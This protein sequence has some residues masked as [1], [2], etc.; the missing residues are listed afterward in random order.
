MGLR[1]L[2]P[3]LSSTVRRLMFS[4]SGGSGGS[5]NPSA[6]PS[7]LLTGLQA[8]YAFE[9]LTFDSTG[10]GNTLT[11]NN[12]VTQASGILGQAASFASASS[13]SLSHA[14]SAPFVMSGNT[15][16]TITG[17]INLATFTGLPPL[18]GKDDGGTTSEYVVCVIQ[19]THEFNFTVSSNG[20]SFVSVSLFSP[21]PTTGTWYFLCA[22]YD[23]VNISLSV[24]N[25]TPVTTAFSA[26]VF[27][28]TSVFNI[29]RFVRT[30]D[31]T[32]GLIDQVGI[33]KVALTPTQITAL[34]GSGSPPAYPFTGIP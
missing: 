2:E 6:A 27:A 33:W 29:G 5:K 18:V 34:Y 23:G 32:N 14:S 1:R 17:W 28:G 31:F 21:V 20:T 10:N 13:Q 11:N 16:F 22:K 9:T 26:G 30:G 19:T 25:G 7:S 8:Y 24:N 4:P 12:G 3:A 15:P